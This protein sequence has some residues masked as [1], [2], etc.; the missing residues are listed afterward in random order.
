MGNGEQR[1]IGDVEC[2]DDAER[3]KCCT[4]KQ[5]DE[6]RQLRCWRR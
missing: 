3:V 4:I 1:R 6:T 2:Q 5:E